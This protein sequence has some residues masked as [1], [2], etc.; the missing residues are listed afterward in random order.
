MLYTHTLFSFDLVEWAINIYQHFFSFF[1]FIFPSL[2]HFIRFFFF[3]FSSILILGVSKWFSFFL[4]VHLCVCAFSFHLLLLI[5]IFVCLL[6]CA[7]RPS[8]KWEKKMPIIQQVTRYLHNEQKC[9]CCY[10]NVFLFSFSRNNF[11][12]ICVCMCVLFVF[13]SLTPIFLRHCDKI[14]TSP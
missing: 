4:A 12:N 11:V 1:F 13:L 10:L 5:I 7:C 9:Y 8:R 6:L 14:L 3:C 2:F